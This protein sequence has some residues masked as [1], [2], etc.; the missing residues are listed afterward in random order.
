MIIWNKNEFHFRTTTAKSKTKYKYLSI[1]DQEKLIRNMN[2]HAH[3]QTHTCSGTLHGKGLTFTITLNNKKIK[4]K[5]RAKKKWTIIENCQE[6]FVC[7]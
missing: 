3:S 7:M 4:R 1:V 5:K 2:N 6:S